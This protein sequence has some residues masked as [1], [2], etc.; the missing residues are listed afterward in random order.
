MVNEDIITPQT[1]PTKWVNSL[2]YP[3][4]PDRT[5]CVCL[6]PSDINTAILWEYDKS[7]PPTKFPTN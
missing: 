6:G 2:N 4:N 1:R 5:L 7:P 3:K